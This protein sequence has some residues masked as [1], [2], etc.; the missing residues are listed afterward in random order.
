MVRVLT[1][2]MN[3][4]KYIL[5]NDIFYAIIHPSEKGHYFTIFSKRR[6]N[7]FPPKGSLFHHLFKKTIK[8][9]PSK[10]VII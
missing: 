7:I 8:Y 4:I 5:H 1:D 3:P 10:R 9:I 2:L 6:S